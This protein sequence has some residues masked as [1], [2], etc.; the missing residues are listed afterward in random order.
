MGL[1]IT[2]GIIKSYGGAITVDST[3]GQ[4][5]TFHVYLPVIHEGVE[6]VDESKE[7]P[8]GEG[9]I[10]FVD[11]EEVLIQMGHDL[12][13]Q[14]GYTVTAQ[15]SSLEALNPFLTLVVSFLQ[16]CVPIFLSIQIKS[17]CCIFL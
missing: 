2:H 10:L 17:I 13:E 9:R 7:A 8:R 3:L 4:G 15:R 11:D 14:L 5:T 6:E 1:S 16:I 12:L